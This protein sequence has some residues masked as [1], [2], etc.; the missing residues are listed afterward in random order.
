MHV[1]DE[2]RLMGTVGYKGVLDMAQRRILFARKQD[3]LLLLIPAILALVVLGQ[4]MAAK[5]PHIFLVFENIIRH[6]S[7]QPPD[8]SSPS[9]LPLRKTPLDAKRATS[10]QKGEVRVTLLTISRSRAFHKRPFALIQVVYLVEFLGD[11]PIETHNSGPVE[12]TGRD[13]K[14]A[15]VPLAGKLNADTHGQ[16]IA[17]DQYQ[18]HYPTGLPSVSDPGRSTVII[19]SVRGTLCKDQG[20]TLTLREGFNGETAEF[21]FSDLSFP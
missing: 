5:W 7:G 18:Y 15:V 12:L 1:A 2:L 4:L 6:G 10:Q 3:F 20:L 11:T 13:G 21:R 9:A 17:Y 19:H 14:P 8:T 16:F